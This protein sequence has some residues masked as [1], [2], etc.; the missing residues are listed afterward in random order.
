MDIKIKWKL[1]GEWQDFDTA[2]ILHLTRNHSLDLFARNIP[3]I[4]RQ[5]DNIISNDTQ[6]RAA[7]HR[8]PKY[9]VIALDKVER[10]DDMLSRVGFV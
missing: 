10:S 6:T 8:N 9:K 1:S 4:I 3:I 7:Y 5:G 2:G